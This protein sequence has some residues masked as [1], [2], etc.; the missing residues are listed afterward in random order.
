MSEVCNNVQPFLFGRNALYHAALQL[1]QRG[2]GRLAVPAYSCGDE[3][4]SLSAAGLDISFYDVRFNPAGYFEA[5]EKSHDFSDEE[6]M[7]TNYFGM[8]MHH[9]GD[10]P[11]IEDDA[12]RLDALNAG[13]SSLFSIFSLRKQLAVPHGALLVSTD[14]LK[15]ENLLPTPDAVITDDN[16]N[17]SS[18][19]TGS[20][21]QGTGIHPGIDH[22]NVFG[23]R[24][25]LQGGYKLTLPYLELPSR[26]DLD[27]RSV[28]LKSQFNRAFTIISEANERINISIAKAMIESNVGFPVIL[29]IPVQNSIHTYEKLKE[30]GFTKAIPF[31]SKTYPR[32]TIDDFPH[33]K[34]LKEKILGL[35]FIYD[36]SNT[37][38]DLLQKCIKEGYIE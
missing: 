1:K 6:V 37:D 22:N 34:S 15:I 11:V 13:S 10:V 28:H 4:E 19:T 2:L 33:A 35:S 26:A 31:W 21:G 17:Y 38:F 12:Y 27:S 29:P 20:T 24:Y 23:A 32:L 18:Y 30:Q 8:K 9:D 3:V 25:R 5:L 14:D 7:V 16:T 36:W